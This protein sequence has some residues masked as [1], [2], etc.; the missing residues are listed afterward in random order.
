MQDSIPGMGRSLNAWYQRIDT[1]RRDLEFYYS[2]G[3][4]RVVDNPHLQL[5]R[6]HTKT[7]NS[8]MPGSSG[9]K[10][11]PL[12]QFE[13]ER[14]SLL[15]SKYSYRKYH[16]DDDDDSITTK[17]LSA[18]SDKLINQIKTPPRSTTSSNSQKLL[19][20]KSRGTPPVSLLSTI[21][22][23]RT[24]ST[25]RVSIENNCSSTSSPTEVEMPP[26]CTSPTV[27]SVTST[28]SKKSSSS[29]ASSSLLIKQLKESLAREKE[30]RVMICNE[31]KDTRMNISLINE[32]L[33]QYVF[34]LFVVLIVIKLKNILK[35]KT[36]R[37]EIEE[38]ST[39]QPEVQK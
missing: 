15:R 34:S 26:I 14:L 21:P 27:C 24:T 6:K 2:A 19:K 1:K 13:K 38:I 3:P 35:K 32:V 30:S 17:T 16:S 5:L 23:L 33:G 39:R 31:L 25:K 9:V 12:E 37:N 18:T 28:T 20:F 36:G 10:G 29:S 11:L 8:F 22:N 4:T 7:N